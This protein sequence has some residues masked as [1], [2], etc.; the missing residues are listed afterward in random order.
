MKK[1]ICILLLL[2]LA[3]PALAEEDVYARVSDALYR[4]VLRTAEGDVTLGSGVVFLDQSV[5]LTAGAYP[6]AGALYA[7]GADGEHGVRSVEWP[8]SAG[9]ALMQL[10]SPSS[11][12]PLGLSDYQ[13][14]GLSHLFGTDDEGN[15]GTVP[16][17]QALHSVYRG[18]YAL[19]LSAEEGLLPGAVMMDE[20]GC[21]VAVV[22]AQQAEGVGM[23]VALNAKAIYSAITGEQ[24]ADAFL[25]LE[26]GWDNGLLT[27]SWI[28]GPREDGL[29]LITISGK[30]NGYYTFFEAD[31]D[32]R[33]F[34]TAVPPGHTYYIQAQWT[35]SEEEAHAPVWSAM[36]EYTVPQSAFTLYGFTQ[37]CFLASAPAGQEITGVLP[38]MTF[39]SADTLA[40]ASRALYLQ[41][42]NTYD[43]DGDIEAPMT[44]ELLAP[45]GQ[46]Y[47]DEL[48]YL[49]SPEYEAE[50][51]FCV[52]LAE[53]FET[54]ARFS[55]NGAMQPG[56]YTL[57]YAI[58]GKTAGE[59][60]FTLHPA[61]TPDPAVGTAAQ[62]DSA[63]LR[64]LKADC[65]SGLIT[66]DW[67]ALDVP[68]GAAVTAYILYDGN[69]YF[70]YYV[71]KPG[72]TATDFYA[73]PGRACMVWASWSLTEGVQLHPG[74]QADVTIVTPAEPV[75]YTLNGFTHVRGGLTLTDHADPEGDGLYLPQTPL[76]REALLDPAMKL[77]FQTEDTYQVEAESGDH[78]LAFV[79]YTPEGYVF[80]EQGMYT[81]APEL[82]ES[83]LWLKDLSDLVA[84]YASL[85]GEN[86]WMAGEYA[87]GCYIDGQAVCEI[88]FTLE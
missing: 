65:A 63:L 16:L 83:D 38:E 72:E 77:V 68:E 9:L 41:I 51:V 58:A 15:V 71:M 76:T 18:Q 46:F 34:Q 78:P 86:V 62:A 7:I 60:A 45:D 56:E 81:F 21:V 36:A 33:S 27:L 39:V 53:L 49:F 24:E 13:T 12:T 74:A 1:L 88:P 29:Y 73:V 66:V 54:C 57:R 52:P 75:P 14:V 87:F 44:L 26:V 61:G 11:A 79:L 82:N 84:E 47:F 50:D 37:E 31:C 30:E 42:T 43:V 28:D 19:L 59:Y 70:T 8:G 5:L 25:D 3:F 40:D 32:Q 48:S 22:M 35:P 17:Y 67:S 85:A 4:I 20:K 55:A 69:E 80:V 64:G 2:T 6:A 23:Y 10:D